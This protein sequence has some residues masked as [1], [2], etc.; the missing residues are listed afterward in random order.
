M[1]VS[2]PG[3]HS[4]RAYLL[5]P[6]SC[7]PKWLDGRGNSTRCRCPSQNWTRLSVPSMKAGVKRYVESSAGDGFIDPLGKSPQTRILADL[8]SNPTAKAG[9]KHPQSG[10]RPPSSWP[11][12][13]D[14]TSDGQV[15]ASISS[16]RTQ[17]PG[18]WSTRFYKMQH[19]PKQSVSSRYQGSERV[20]H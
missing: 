9:A 20:S 7:G 14:P 12:P 6:S 10:M 18:Y 8:Q 15:D 16:K 2:R 4:S 17:T 13:L 19:I 5:L 3:L 1:G 11:L